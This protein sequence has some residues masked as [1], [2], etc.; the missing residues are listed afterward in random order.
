MGQQKGTNTRRW[1]ILGPQFS[2][3][4]SC[5]TCLLCSLCNCIRARTRVVDCRRHAMQFYKI[6]PR[7][8]QLERGRRL[9]HLRPVLVLQGIST[10]GA[11]RC[12]TRC[13]E[14]ATPKDLL[15][16]VGGFL[17]CP[18]FMPSSRD[19]LE[20][21]HRRRTEQRRAM[22]V[23]G[24]GGRELGVVQMDLWLASGGVASRN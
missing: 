18:R 12:T 3:L 1:M 17:S 19:S 14:T 21:G 9:V 15:R 11:A 23:G 7:E 6:H 20:S 2:S 10:R 8:L 24:Y 4:M 16:A 22:M 13:A 5:A